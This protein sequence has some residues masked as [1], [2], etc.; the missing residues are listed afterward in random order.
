MHTSDIFPEG[1]VP[2]DVP[3]HSQH[4]VFVKELSERDRHVLV[5]IYP[6]KWWRSM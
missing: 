1:K 4:T 2:G 6:M 5:P 3:A